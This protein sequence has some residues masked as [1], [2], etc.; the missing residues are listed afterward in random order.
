M[1]TPKNNVGYTLDINENQGMLANGRFFEFLSPKN[2]NQ[3]PTKW[4]MLTTGHTMVSKFDLPKFTFKIF[5]NNAEKEVEAKVILDGRDQWD[6]N[7][8]PFKALLPEDYQNIELHS[9]LDYAIVEVNFATPE[10]AKLFTSTDWQDNILFS[11]N[12]LDN[13]LGYFDKN[14][15]NQTV[16]KSISNPNRGYKLLYK[17]DGYNKVLWPEFTNSFLIDQRLLKI[18]GQNY[19]DFST[20]FKIKATNF[21]EGSSGVVIGNYRTNLWIKTAST[22]EDGLWLPTRISEKEQDVFKSILATRTNAK[23]AESWSNLT[24]DIIGNFER[25]NSGKSFI[26]T[27][28]KLYPESEPGFLVK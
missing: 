27:F 12:E 3:Y 7:L 18:N 5:N 1:T 11:Q 8:E 21:P 2:T 22:N 4:F 23:I 24:Y 14:A 6:T 13:Q 17:K 10:D 19:I 15:N 25:E 26:K 28:Q 16:Y 20:N 9:Y